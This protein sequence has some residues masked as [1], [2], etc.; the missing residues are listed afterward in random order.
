MNS[1]HHKIILWTHFY[2]LKCPDGSLNCLGSNFCGTWWCTY[3]QVFFDI[4]VPACE[5]ITVLISDLYTHTYSWLLGD[6]PFPLQKNALFQPL[7]GSFLMAIIHENL[8]YSMKIL[9]IFEME[10]VKHSL[11]NKPIH[12]FCWQWAKEFYPLLIVQLFWP[13]KPSIFSWVIQNCA[14]KI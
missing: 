12:S 5:Q 4:P 7:Y 9:S 2:C 11:L 6:S 10:V 3:E 14:W 13:L 1:I 8:P